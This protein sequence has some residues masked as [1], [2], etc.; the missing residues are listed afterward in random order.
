MCCGAVEHVF[1]LPC[2]RDPETEGGE[3]SRARWVEWY[4]PDE[5][6]GEKMEK[7]NSG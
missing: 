3:K 1:A 7:G 6:R 2:L 5:I 4:V